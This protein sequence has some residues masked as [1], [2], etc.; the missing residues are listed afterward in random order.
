MTDWIKMV[1]KGA[2]KHVK[3]LTGGMGEA[4]VQARLKGLQPE[5]K[6][7]AQQLLQQHYAEKGYPPEQAGVLAI[8][9]IEKM[10]GG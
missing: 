9:D 3:R 1:T 7:L 6:P 8:Q 5:D 4:E 2:E 10:Y